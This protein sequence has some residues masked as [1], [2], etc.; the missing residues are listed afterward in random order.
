[1]SVPDCYSTFPKSR[2]IEF[3]TLSRKVKMSRHFFFVQFEQ[4][5]NNA[6]GLAA[7]NICVGAQLVL[8]N[9]KHSAVRLQMDQLTI[10]NQ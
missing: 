5:S 3:E 1:M 7:A 2:C 6:F 10:R 9:H 8:T 4:H